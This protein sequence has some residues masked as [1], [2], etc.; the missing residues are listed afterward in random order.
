MVRNR[1]MTGGQLVTFLLYL[2]SLSDAFSTIGWVFTS[3]TQAVGAADKVFELLHRQPKR[4]DPSVNAEPGSLC[5]TDGILGIVATKTQELRA[6]GLK[7]DLASGEVVFDDV[8]FFYPARPKRKILDHLSLRIPPGSV[9]ALVGPSGGG[10]SS[11]L[12]LIQHLY[13]P[14]SGSVQLDGV[15]VHELSPS[16]LSKNVAVV[17]Q[18]PTLFA[19]SIKD[20]IT[21]G[22]E[23]APSIEEIH[24]AA[25]LANAH[26]FIL[27]MPQG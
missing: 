23:D 21:Y 9:V 24:D 14:T 15:D 16:W 2:Q 1:D 6:R 22:I 20:N 25:R 11:I 18:E 7:P 17:S 5:T 12:S 19:R 26:E 10:K 8:V 13:E 27:S 3:L 4:R